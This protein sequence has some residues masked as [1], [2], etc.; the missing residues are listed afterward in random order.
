VDAFEP[1]IEKARAAGIHD[2]YIITRL[3]ALDIADKSYDAVIL[4]DLIEHFEKEESRAFL[5][6]LERLA[7][8]RVV[9]FTPNGFLPQPAYDNN[10]WQ[11]HLCGWDVEDFRKAG[12]RVQGTLGFKWLR[13]M[14]HNPRIRPM[15][16]GERI[17]NLTHR[18]WTRRRPHLDAALFAVKDLQ[19]QPAGSPE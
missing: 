14:Y 3:D 13:G 1:S 4:M 17:A 7:R 2:E 18:L 6:R 9:V 19:P 11:E 10:P 12:Y 5:Q 8:R 16:I 15:F